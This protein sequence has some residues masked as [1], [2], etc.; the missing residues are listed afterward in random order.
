MKK[1]LHLLSILFVIVALASGCGFHSAVVSQ[2]NNNITRVDLGQNNFKVVAKVKGESSATYL[3]GL[4][5][6]SQRALIENARSKMLE[7]ADLV[8]KPRAIINTTVESHRSLFVPLFYKRT[9]TVSGF[10][11]EFT[12]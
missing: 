12:D 11:I 4:G 2:Q 6:L 8:D 7:E 1:S 5:G 3:F 9:V 10:V